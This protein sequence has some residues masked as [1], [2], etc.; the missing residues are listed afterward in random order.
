MRGR[1]DPVR[2]REQ[3][4]E[5]WN[6]LTLFGALFLNPLHLLS[7]HPSILPSLP[8]FLHAT[9]TVV[10]LQHKHAHIWERVVSIVH[11]QSTLRY[12]IQQCL[13]K[14]KSKHALENDGNTIHQLL[15]RQR[16][17]QTEASWL[18]AA[19][20]QKYTMIDTCALIRL[21]YCIYAKYKAWFHTHT[22]THT[23]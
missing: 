18:I 13:T 23:Q 11:S 4:E 22:K 17:E 15:L 20:M 12:R 1:R 7:L 2:H 9:S 19:G 8:P 3:K 6:S 5:D 16:P 10:A 14:I 21:K